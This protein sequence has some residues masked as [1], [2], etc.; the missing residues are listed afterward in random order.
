[1]ILRV[2]QPVDPAVQ[3]ARPAHRAR[4]AGQRVA[5]VAQ[6]RQRRR[7]RQPLH[8][9]D[10]IGIEFERGVRPQLQVKPQTLLVL[11]KMRRA[12]Q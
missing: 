2:D 9:G 12:R 7:N 3:I 4:L 5:D 10:L 11:G 6:H 1:M 8:E